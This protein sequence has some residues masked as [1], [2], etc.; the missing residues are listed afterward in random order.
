[1]DGESTRVQV[2]RSFVQRFAD[3]ESVFE[4]GDEGSHLYI[5]QSG[6]VEIAR[7][8][9]AGKRIVA[10]VG[11]GE[12]FGEMSVLLGEPRTAQAT[13][14]GATELLELDGETLEGMCIERPEIAIRLIQRLATRLIG[15]ERRLSALGL[16][17]L[18]AP[19]I[20]L[21]AAHAE[22]SDCEDELRLQT[23]LRALAEG[24][25]LSLHETYQALHQLMDQKLVRVN[26]DELIVPDLTALTTALTRFAIPA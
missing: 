17:Q 19:L 3:G 13:A 22:A 15:A 23:S 21:L 26:G 6:K 16:D 18:V 1:M 12:F 5:V 7:Q 9:R 2:A 20:R 4:E 11:P 25:A 14:M 8:S 24:S 10:Q